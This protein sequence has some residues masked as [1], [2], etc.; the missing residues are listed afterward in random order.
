MNRPPEDIRTGLLAH[1]V[2]ARPALGLDLTLQ[3]AAGEVVALVGPNGAGK[4]TALHA[5]AGLVPLQG[6]R[7]VLDD[8]VLEDVEAGRHVHAEHRG[9]GVVF[10]DHRLFAHLSALENVAFARRAAGAT[11]SAARTEAHGWL[12]EVG[13]ADVTH[14]RAVRLSGGQQQRVALARALAARPRALLLDE[15][16]TAL[17][18]QTRGALRALVRRHVDARGIPAVLVTHDAADAGDLADWVVTLHEGRRR[19]D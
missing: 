17:D 7:V 10:Q 13:L 11:A 3:V 4:S 14:Q 6:G 8:V 5:L 19:P 18:A 1:L 16:F 15:P 12:A 2:V 9:F